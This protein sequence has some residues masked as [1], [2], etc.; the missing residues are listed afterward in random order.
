MFYFSSGGDNVGTKCYKAADVSIRHTVSTLARL[1][2]IG[3]SIGI[4]EL[5]TKQLLLPYKTS[6]IRGSSEVLLLSLNDITASLAR[7]G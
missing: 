5:P 1:N 3:D 2:D 7:E 6:F 4:S